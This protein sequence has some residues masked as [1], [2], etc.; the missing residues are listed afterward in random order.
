MTSHFNVQIC[1]RFPTGSLSPSLQSHCAGA[2]VA[3]TNIFR[4]VILSEIPSLHFDVMCS[5]CLSNSP[6]SPSPLPYPRKPS[7]RPYPWLFE[8]V[9]FK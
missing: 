5:L 4:N 6:F 2:V 3:L 9:Y 7:W 8:L 1:F